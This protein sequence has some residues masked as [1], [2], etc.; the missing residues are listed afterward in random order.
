MHYSHGSRA[1]VAKAS[2]DYYTAQADFR[3]AMGDLEAIYARAIESIDQSA[4]LITQ[5]TVRAEVLMSAL[6]GQV[7]RVNEM[8]AALGDDPLPVPNLVAE[9]VGRLAP[10]GRRI[11]HTACQGDVARTARALGESVQP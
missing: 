5:M 7:G 6:A 11:Y 4:D 3:S 9:L 2:T 10:R 8:R 1:A